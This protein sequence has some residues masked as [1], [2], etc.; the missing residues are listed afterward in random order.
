MGE[1]LFSAFLTNLGKTEMPAELS[2][3]VRDIQ[4]VPMNHPY[5]KTGCGFLTYFDELNLN[6]VRNIQ[7]DIV[8]EKF[9]QRLQDFG[10]EVQVKRLF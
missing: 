2:E 9:I 6:F 7:E 3:V 5:F 4:I 10:L 1:E 8:E